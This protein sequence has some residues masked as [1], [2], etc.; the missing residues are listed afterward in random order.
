LRDGDSI[1]VVD[2]VD[3]DAEATFE[4]LIDAGFSPLRVP[5]TPDL[6]RM[7][8][9]VASDARAVICDHRLAKDEAGRGVPY[10]G[11]EVVAR[12][13]E[14]GF[15]A[16]LITTWAN[17]DEATSIRRFRDR[18]PRVLKR[19]RASGATV[20]RDALEAAQAETQ[21]A[22][23]AER[24]AHRT[25]VRVVQVEDGEDPLAE[26]IVS[27]WRPDEAILVPCALIVDDTSLATADLL[28][29]RFLADVNIHAA[30]EADLYFR[31]FEPLSEP[32]DDW[33]RP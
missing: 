31:S 27:A 19:G 14:R 3:R 32:P 26:V 21:G 18:I 15:A 9:S 20:I 10:T 22:Y 7:V 25:I 33:M 13:S 8:E 28:G 6:D 4:L 16:V 30:D 23:A 2:D 29:R 5:I 24:Q 17:A 12:C 1:G 11:A